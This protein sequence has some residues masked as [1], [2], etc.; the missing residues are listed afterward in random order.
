[1]LNFQITSGSENREKM[2]MKEKGDEGIEKAK[3]K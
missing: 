1:M 3:V 2:D